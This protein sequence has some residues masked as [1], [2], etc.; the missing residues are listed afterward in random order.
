M[1]VNNKKKLTVMKSLFY[2]FDI[3]VVICEGKI[4]VNL[5]KNKKKSTVTKSLLNQFV[6]F[7]AICKDLNIFTGDD[8]ITLVSFILVALILFG[9][10]VVVV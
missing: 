1:I 4:I 3:F 2:Q 9:V 6:I 10:I 8:D 5:T 7:V